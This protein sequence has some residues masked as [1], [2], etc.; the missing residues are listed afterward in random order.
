MPHRFVT[1][2]QERQ[3]HPGKGGALPRGGEGHHAG[4]GDVAGTIQTWR[5]P[6]GASVR[7]FDVWPSCAHADVETSVEVRRFVR[8]FVV[9]P[10]RRLQSPI[11]LK[12]VPAALWP[13]QSRGRWT[14]TDRPTTPPPTRCP[15]RVWPEPCA[16]PE[17][18]LLSPSVA[19]ARTPA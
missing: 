9:T 17:R 6:G 1:G 13:R 12:C 11:G 14:S 15:R 10:V 16:L 4:D 5:R 8:R 2:S 3:S 19:A 7:T 18:Q